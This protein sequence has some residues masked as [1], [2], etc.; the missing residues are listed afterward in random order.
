MANATTLMAPHT[1]SSLIGYS[2][3]AGSYCPGVQAWY[4]AWIKPDP[5]RADSSGVPSQARLRSRG[6]LGEPARRP[7][8]R[9]LRADRLQDD[10]LVHGGTSCFGLILRLPGVPDR[11]G[12]GSITT[13][14]DH[15]DGIFVPDG[16][17]GVTLYDGE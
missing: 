14:P 5:T 1:G 4:N 13:H 15:H 16:S 17:G 10:R 11:V 6:D 12:F 3:A 8:C 7:G 9:R 2:C